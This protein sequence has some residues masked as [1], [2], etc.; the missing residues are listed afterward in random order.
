[1]GEV[2]LYGGSEKNT[3]DLM[4]RCLRRPTRVSTSASNRSSHTRQ[5]RPG[6]GLCFQGKVTESHKLFPLR[7]VGIWAVRA[8][9]WMYL[10][11]LSKS[12]MDAS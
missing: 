4:K 7:I 10:R 12:N 8:P 3:Q 11:G 2:P 6:P 1:M 9:E 5:S